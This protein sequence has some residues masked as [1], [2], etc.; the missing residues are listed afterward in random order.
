MSSLKDK[1]LFKPIPL[2][3]KLFS[4]ILAPIV[5]PEVPTPAEALISPVGFSSTIKLTIF[6]PSDEPSFIS[7][8]TLLKN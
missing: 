8:D 2:P 5:D 3:R 6:C 1:E 7:L 4:L